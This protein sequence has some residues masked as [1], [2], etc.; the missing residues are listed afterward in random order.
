MQMSQKK[1]NQNKNIKENKQT[2]MTLY[3]KSG[4]NTTKESQSV[5]FYLKQQKKHPEAGTGV[6][7]LW[8]LVKLFFPAEINQHICVWYD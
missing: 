2:E 8:F 3:H 6:D 7:T 5:N 4:T 1:Q